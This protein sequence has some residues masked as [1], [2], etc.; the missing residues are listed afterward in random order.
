MTRNVKAF[1]LALVASLAMSAM[2]ASAAQAESFWFT[3]EVA[4]T[5]LTGSQKAAFFDK[6]KT[7]SGT[8]T[9]EKITYTGSQTGTTA[10][11]ITIIPKYEECEVGGVSLIIDMNGCDYVFTQHTKVE[12]TKYTVTT[13]IECPTTA[14]GVTDEIKIT[15]VPPGGTRKCTINIPEQTIATGT[16]LTNGT[17]GAT[18]K[19]DLTAD[20]SI[21]SAF[22]ATGGITY[23]ETAGTGTGACTTKNDTA[24]GTYIGEA[25]INGENAAGEAKN[26]SL[27]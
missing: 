7:D 20:I 5:T 15:I 9:C 12:T 11:T 16:T 4:S 3:S 17:N 14:G 25:T 19:A 27:G 13:K 1:G 23:S 21:N 2:V 18:G 6:F 26:I 10:S 8:V 22:A 24:N